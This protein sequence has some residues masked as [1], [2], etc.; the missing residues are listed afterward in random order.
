MWQKFP[1]Y[2]TS[3]VRF[4]IPEN[5]VP[6]EKLGTDNQYFTKPVW[7]CALPRNDSISP[8][9]RE[10]CLAKAKPQYIPSTAALKMP[11]A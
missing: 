11:P 9:N 5:V 1:T 6:I 8:W 10:S 7:F 3:M 2:Y 4:S